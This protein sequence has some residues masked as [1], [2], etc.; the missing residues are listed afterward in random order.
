MTISSNSLFIGIDPDLHHTAVAIADAEGYIIQV[1]CLTIPSKLKQTEAV[2]ATAFELSRQLYPLVHN[3]SLKGD[4]YRKK[5]FFIEDQELVYASKGKKKANPRDLH[6]LGQVSGA[7]IVAA[8]GCLETCEVE[9]L[10]PFQWKGNA[11]KDIHHARICNQ[12]GWDY[13]IRGGK[14]PYAV[15]SNHGLDV[16][17]SAGTWKHAMDAAGLALKGREMVLAQARKDK[18]LTAARKERGDT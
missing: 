4:E 2:K 9:L 7:A 17:F 18:A 5:Y 14:D 15:P 16:T 8:Y 3:A 10:K 6:L 13:T 1:K 12:L 11:P